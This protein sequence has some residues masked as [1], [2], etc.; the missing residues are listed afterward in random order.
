MLIVSKI[1]ALGESMQT[2]ELPFVSSE[3]SSQYLGFNIVL[4][5]IKT[6]ET[7]ILKSPSYSGVA[8]QALNYKPYG[9]FDI[10]SSGEFVFVAVSSQ[11][12]KF[13]GYVDSVDIVKRASCAVDVSKLRYSKS[14]VFVNSFLDDNCS[15]VH[16]GIAPGIEY[17]CRSVYCTLFDA[18]CIVGGSIKEDGFYLPKYTFS[19][20]DTTGCIEDAYVCRVT[21]EDLKKAG[22]LVVKSVTLEKKLMMDMYQYGIEYISNDIL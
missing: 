22:T 12:Y 9:F 20:D 16:L 14:N 10:A 6:K 17:D 2:L 13:L 3:N 19:S 11:A 8:N 5:D 18:I 1:R 7:V 21:C 15:I 4:L